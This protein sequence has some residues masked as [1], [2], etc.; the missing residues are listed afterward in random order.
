MAKATPKKRPASRKKAGNKRSDSHSS[1]PRRVRTKADTFSVLSRVRLTHPD[2]IVYSDKGITKR[3]VAEYYTLVAEWMLPQIAN[4]PLSI[5][6]CPEGADG[7]CFFQK[8]PPFGLSTSVKR[9]KIQE[10]SGRNDYLVVNNLEGI[11]ALVQFG[12]L[13]LHVWGSRADDIEHPDRLVFDLD[14]DPNMPWSKVVEAALLVRDALQELDL[15][16][17]VKTTGGKGIHIVVPIRR[18]SSWDEAKEFTH[19][20]A[21]WI[22][23]AAPDRYIA[24]MSKAA[25][26]GKI[27]VDYLRNQRGATAV[28]VYSTRARAGATVSAPL[29]WQELQSLKTAA[30]FDITTVPQRLAKQRRDPWAAIDT[31]RQAIS[32]TVKKK[33]SI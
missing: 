18:T 10:G 12:A 7:Q 4:R 13:E 15:V 25:R 29:E 8:H 9:I 16:S 3:Q 32:S 22:V 1:I 6:R 19:A 24:N 2:R 31:I 21:D 33:L 28:A 20:V 30:E 23:R 17:F 14:P 11:L 26:K 5:V 27:F